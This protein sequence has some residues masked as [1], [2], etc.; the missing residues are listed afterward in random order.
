MT[1]ARVSAM[2]EET[3]AAWRADRAAAGAPLPE[4]EPGDGFEAL[5]VVLDDVEVG[6]VVLSYGDD[7]DSGGHR[8]CSIRL[9]QTTVP[10]DAGQAWAAIVTALEEHAGARGA[11]SLVTAVPPRLAASFQ[12]AGFGATMTGVRLQHPEKERVL[13]EDGRVAVRT[14]TDDERRRFAAEAPGL[15][16]EG[17]TTAGVLS[18][19]EAPMDRLER[20]LA[21]LA[22]DPP[23]EELLLTALVGEEPAGRFWATLAPGD[24]GPDLLGN[25]LDLFPEFRGQGLTRS[26]MA[27]V[28]TWVI[29]HDVRGITGLLYGADRE[30]RATVLGMGADLGEIHLRKDFG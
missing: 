10:D 25:Y 15:M 18:G 2:P 12:A 27:A 8:R 19:P 7:G 26:F 13:A 17:M 4:P 21:G 3:L 22:V 20:R 9:L 23:P 5:A 1:S 11:R 28:E 24:G 16:R 6:G 29:A 14:M 30:A